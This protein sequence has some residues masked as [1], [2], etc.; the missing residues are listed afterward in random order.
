MSHISPRSWTDFKASSSWLMFKIMSE[1]V[2]GFERMDKMNPC[3]CVFGSARTK[4]G[5]PYYEKTV[6]LSQALAKEGFGIIT[7]GGPGIMEAA[8]KGAWME[9]ATSVGLNI[10][11]PHEQGANPYIDKDK[12]FNFKYFYVRKVMFLKY[13]QA[14]VL[15]PGGFG[16]MDEM[17]ETLTLVQTGK[18]ERIPI[19]LFGSE[20]WK[21]LLDWIKTTMCDQEHNIN[22]VDLELM[23]LTDDPQD[24]IKI[25]NEHYMQTS[26]KPTF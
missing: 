2:D 16:T 11:L 8:N 18:I 4:P 19:I 25:I 14:V 23:H 20:Y 17:F 22:P 1:F 3:I 12:I 15:M 24:V 26:L 6:S 13:S 7:G 9:K 10:E 5:T 21:G